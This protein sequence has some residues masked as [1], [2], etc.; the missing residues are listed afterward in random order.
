MIEIQGKI[1]AQ[2]V[3]SRNLP[4]PFLCGQPL[5]YYYTSQLVSTNMG[6]LLAAYNVFTVQC[7][8]VRR[9]RILLILPLQYDGDWTPEPVKKRIIEVMYSWT[10]GLPKET[11]IAEAY[12]MLKQQGNIICNEDENDVLISK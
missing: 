7:Y 6:F 10:I 9:L 8:D 2:S 1:L 11:K 3:K 5:N 4:Y 12:K